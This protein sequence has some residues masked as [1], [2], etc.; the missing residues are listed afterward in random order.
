MLIGTFCIENNVKLLH[1]DKGFL[2]LMELGLE[3]VE[4]KLS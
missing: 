4:V 3:L 1:H 2:P